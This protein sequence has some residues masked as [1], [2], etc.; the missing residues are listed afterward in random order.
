MRKKAIVVVALL[1]GGSLVQLRATTNHVVGVIAAIERQAA[2]TLSVA[3]KGM[4]T[5]TVRTN[6][7]TAYMKWI[8]HKPWQRDNSADTR[9]LVEGRCVNV[10]LR[11]DDASVAKTIWISDEPAGSFYDPCRTR[12]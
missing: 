8:N 5:Q 1:I 11:A 3:A 2:P 6:S 12:R 10:D 9:S 4:E 7:Q